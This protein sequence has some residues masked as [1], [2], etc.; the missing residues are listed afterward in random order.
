M[1]VAYKEDQYAELTNRAL[2]ET[3]RPA[4]VTLKMVL[5]YFAACA[6]RQS[7]YTVPDNL[8]EAII[9]LRDELRPSFDANEMLQTDG[10][11]LRNQLR[12]AI[13]GISVIM[14]WNCPKIGNHTMV[15][16][17]RYDTPKPDYDFIDL[18][19]LCRNVAFSVIR[20]AAIED[21][22]DNSIPKGE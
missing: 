6:I 2:A 20:E 15:F 7:P 19:A 11:V 10:R 3:E 22:W 4:W 16:V 1:S 9:L 13:E 5:G 12:A 21:G 18:D 14:D 8:S 17:S